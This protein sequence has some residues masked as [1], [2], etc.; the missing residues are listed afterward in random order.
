MKEFKK[1]LREVSKDP[2]FEI[3]KSLRK[4]TIKIVHIDSGS[5]YSVHPADHA[6]PSIKKW[7]ENKRNKDVKL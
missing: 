5:L 2:L 7:V 6:V 3:K 4:S 1:F